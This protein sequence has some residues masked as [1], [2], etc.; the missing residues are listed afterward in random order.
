MRA[1]FL[2]LAI[3]ASVFTNAALVAAGAGILRAQVNNPDAVKLELRNI[4]SDGDAAQVAA[5]Q[6]EPG[7][8][9][10]FRLRA[11]NKTLVRHVEFLHGEAVGN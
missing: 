7:Q 4:A 1:K 5:S 8:R 11:S 3:L 6:F 10:R 2:A 9:V